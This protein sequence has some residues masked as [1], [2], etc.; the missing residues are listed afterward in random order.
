MIIKEC[1]QTIKDPRGNLTGIIYLQNRHRIIYK[2]EEAD[3]DEI[4]HLLNDDKPPQDDKE[5]MSGATY[6]NNEPGNR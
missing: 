2:V 6:I 1:F 5:D 4:E 3:D